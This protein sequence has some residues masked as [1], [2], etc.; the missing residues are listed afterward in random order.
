MVLC[1]CG[2]VQLWV[3]Y[4]SVCSGKQCV[5]GLDVIQCLGS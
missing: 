3:S 1:D 2:V 5:F 4:G